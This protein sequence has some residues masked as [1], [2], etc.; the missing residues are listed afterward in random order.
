M[1]RAHKVLAYIHQVWRRP[2]RLHTID[3]KG[4]ETTLEYPSPD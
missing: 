3:G 1:G 2:V 4:K